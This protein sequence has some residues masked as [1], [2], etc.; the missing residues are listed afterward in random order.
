MSDVEPS[1]EG[2][3]KRARILMGILG[4]IALAG[5][6]AP[7]A[8][9]ATAH[10]RLHSTPL[11]HRPTV[12]SHVPRQ[13]TMPRTLTVQKARVTVPAT[14]AVRPAATQYGVTTASAHGATGHISLSASPLRAASAD[15]LLPGQAS[16]GVG[17]PTVQPT[18]YEAVWRQSAG[19]SAIEQLLSQNGTLYTFIAHG[20]PAVVQSLLAHWHH[21]A[22]ATVTDAVH[23]MQHI[24]M[25]D[26]S[27]SQWHQD[28]WE[29]VGGPGGAGMQS[30]YLFHTVNGGRAWTLE[31]RTVL[32]TM[33]M[34]STRRTFLAARGIAQMDFWTAQDGVIAEAFEEGAFVGVYRTTNGG[35]TWKFSRIL[36]PNLPTAETLHGV[37]PVLTLSV[38]VP[39]YPTTVERSGNGGLTWS[40]GAS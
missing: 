8:R 7:I 20:T 25:P 9:G 22:V 39:G 30:F 40:T 26:A 16:V 37:G 23:W 18:L 6:G 38:Q 12:V 36:L 17:A 14:W 13:R 4:S 32:G 21:P 24:A 2:I 31:R 19:H 11:R 3:M 29:L 34:G 27:A 15:Q 35:H 33:P 10:H 5:C 1:Q 28:A